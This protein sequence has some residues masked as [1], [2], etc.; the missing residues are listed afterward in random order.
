METTE[1]IMSELQQKFPNRRAALALGGAALAGLAFARPSRAKA[2][3][4]VDDNDIL[5]FAL[6]LEYLEA[7]YYT[8]A[9]QGVTIDTLGI[10]ITGPGGA[11]GGS[12]TVKASPMVPFQTPALKQFAMEVALEERNHVA[13]LRSALGDTAAVAQPK[14][15][16]LNSFNALAT[17]AG[18]G[19][20]FDPFA[21]ETNFLLGAFIFED[22]GVT[23]YLGA[24]GLIS[25][26]TY[27]DKAAGILA[28][29]AYHAGSIR[30]RV[31]A[32]G[33]SA[34]A[35]ATL[36]AKARAKLDGTGND[37]IGVGVDSTG[38]ATIV[39]ADSNALAFSRTTTQVLSIVYGGGSASGAFY[40]VGMNGT[41]K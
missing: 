3:T 26:A 27:L 30:T 16:L 21:N 25:S 31:Y 34:Q 38:A 18:L 32:A 14:I 33:T 17:A 23:A 5:N 8:L 35:A 41:I 6:N 13:F 15:D 1:T 28:V 29:E 11:A 12:V 37:D 39:D 4:T 9:T 19:S 36:I 20:T 10:G 7:Q 22:V 40:P 24:A 2:A